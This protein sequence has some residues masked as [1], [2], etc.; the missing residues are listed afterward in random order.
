MLWNFTIQYDTILTSTHKTAPYIKNLRLL[1]WHSLVNRSE[2][3]LC[4]DPSLK[5]QLTHNSKD[6]RRIQHGNPNS[7]ERSP[8]RTW[9]VLGMDSSGLMLSTCYFVRQ[10][11]RTSSEYYEATNWVVREHWLRWLTR[12]PMVCRPQYFIPFFRI[13]RRVIG[14]R[15]VMAILL[16]L[17]Y[18]F[19]QSSQYACWYTGEHQ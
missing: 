5:S 3:R 17:F 8:L 10:Q 1:K 2:L 16:S 14:L 6:Y 9:R 4:L 7:Y 19:I 12:H 15:S 18:A 11:A 13:A